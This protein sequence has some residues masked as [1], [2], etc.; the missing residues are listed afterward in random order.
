MSSAYPTFASPAITAIMSDHRER[1][2]DHERRIRNVTLAIANTC[3][4]LP[5][6]CPLCPIESTCPYSS[7]KTQ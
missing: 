4:R 1:M 3:P 7:R 2:R 6:A 5:G